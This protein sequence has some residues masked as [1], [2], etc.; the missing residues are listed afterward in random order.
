MSRHVVEAHLARTPSGLLVP[1][2]HIGLPPDPPSRR[3]LSPR[4]QELWELANRLGA[5]A[6]LQTWQET[7]VTSQVDGPT[8][9]AAA[10]ATAIPPAALITIPAGWWQI[11]RCMKITAQGRISC[12]V[13]TP[14]TARWQ[15]RQAAVSVF[16]S[17]AL[18]LNVV[19]KVTVPWWLEIVMT[20]RAIGNGVNANLFGFGSFQSEAVVGSPVNTAGG[21]GSLVCPV[22]APVVGTGFD[23]TIA[24]ILDLFFTQT[25]A[26]GSMTVHQYKVEALN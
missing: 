7:L 18:N 12:V 20:C 6:S 13:T 3:F 1:A 22:G 17:G 8:L 11:G 9:V 4:L 5:T 16:D 26:T 2:H 19:A 10:A 24:N 23:S 21:N 25:V 14:G 15:V